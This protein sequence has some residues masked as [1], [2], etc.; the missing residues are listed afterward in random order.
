[1]TIETTFPEK[2]NSHRAFSIMP[3]A[4]IRSPAN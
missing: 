4:A 3:G 1:M 2:V